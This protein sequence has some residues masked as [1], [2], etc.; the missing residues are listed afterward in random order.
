MNAISYTK[1][2]NKLAQMMAKVCA[3]HEPVMITRNKKQTVVMISL[4]DYQA[5]EET[6]YLLRSP[7][8]A[9]RLLESIL[10]LESG[11]GSERELIE[12]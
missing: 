12:T 4:E 5:L 2:R 9:K 10:E 6:A 1:I 8:N 3:D 7:E 11:S